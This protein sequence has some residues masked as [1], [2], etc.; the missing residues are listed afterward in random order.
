MFT[1][2]NRRLKANLH[3]FSIK[4]FVV[5]CEIKESADDVDLLQGFQGE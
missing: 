5:S 2:Q 4:L 1:C 3:I